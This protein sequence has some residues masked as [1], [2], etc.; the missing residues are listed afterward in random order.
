[1]LGDE[2]LVGRVGS[3]EQLGLG[4]QRVHRRGSADQHVV[5]VLGPAERRHAF[6]LRRLDHGAHELVDGPDVRLDQPL[7][8]RG[9]GDAL[10]DHE[11]VQL[12][13]RGLEAHE[14]AK[15]QAQAG[16]QVHPLEAGEA[17]PEGFAEQ[18]EDAVG[19]RLPE[20]FLGGEVVGQRRERHVGAPRDLARGGALEA[21]RRE[22]LEGR[23][24]QSLAGLEAAL[25]RARRARAG[26]FVFSGLTHAGNIV[27]MYLFVK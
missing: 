17:L 5:Q 11:A 18:P 16:R 7:E 20:R 9:L 4:G 23:L 12:R 10:L 1:M 14:V 19:G 25:L 24:D 3:G 15:D 21:V 22:D 13:V 26:G 27:Q 2:R 8:P 6:P